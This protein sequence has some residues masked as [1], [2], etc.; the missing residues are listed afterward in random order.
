MGII[1]LPNSIYSTKKILVFL[2]IDERMVFVFGGLANSLSVCAHACDGGK[3]DF[4][5]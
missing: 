1:M 4:V 5:T 2:I 3:N